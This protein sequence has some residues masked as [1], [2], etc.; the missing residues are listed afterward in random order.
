MLRAVKIRLYPNREQTTQINKLLGCYRV[1][2]NQ[3]LA[4][5]IKSYEETK[6]SE[7]LSTLGYFVHHELLK[8]DNFIWLREQNTKVL[9]Q[10]VKDML[11]AYKNFFERHTGYPKF[12]SKHNNKQSCRFEL[13]AISKRNDY[14]TYHLSLANI[15][16]IRFRCNEKYAQYLQKYHDNIRQATLT[17]L[18]CG[19][20]YLSI[21]VDGGL[22]H[23]V[24]ESNDAVGIDLG[25]KDFVITSDGEVFDNL[26]FKKSETKK[27]K[28][29]QCQLSKKQKGSKNRN[30]A[31][32][33]L[34]KLYKKIND[35]K[36]YYLHAVSNSLIDENQVICMEDLNVKGMVKNH[37]L[38]ESICEMNFGEF[39]RMLEYK[40]KWYNRKIVFVDRFYPSSKM[41]HNC[42]YV[43]KELRLSDRQ[44][45][46][47]VCGEVIE[48]DYNAA[49]N[50]LDEG[51]RIIGCSTSEFTLVDYPTAERRTTHNMC[52][53]MDDR[54]ES[55]LKS[56]GRLKQEVSNEQTS[57][58][59]F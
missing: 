41:C 7:N 45:I 57:L 24:K 44:W 31:R 21:L 6:T 13:G 38:A 1:V 19:E 32:I 12:K 48:R 53:A 49:L 16:N 14:S 2:Y 46:C 25:V 5:K 27:I 8:D 56:S 30:K 35:R 26:H 23:K 18:P 54:C 59:K 55:N 51:L 20:Y 42:G 17:K 4:R 40:A 39:R 58:F 52:G 43:N 3:C 9:K 11:S 50:I 29:L 22:T 34:A 47:P 36:Q 15:K 28:G 10:A 33:K 37:N